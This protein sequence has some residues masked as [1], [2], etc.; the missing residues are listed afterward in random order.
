MRARRCNVTE[1]RRRQATRRR[2]RRGTTA[3]LLV[4]AIAL[5][6]LTPGTRAE[7]QVGASSF[8]VS[9]MKSMAEGAAS[10]AGS[11]LFG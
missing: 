1:K 11:D 10:T 7:A 6:G 2:L 3:A 9:L 5:S 4:V 8:V